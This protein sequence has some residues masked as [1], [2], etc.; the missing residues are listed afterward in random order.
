MTGSRTGVSRPD[1]SKPDSTRAMPGR[2]SPDRSVAEDHDQAPLPASGVA[3]MHGPA[4]P[5]EGT[6]E[7]H[8]DDGAMF[9]R[10]AP[11][12]GEDQGSVSAGA[13]PG[14]PAADGNLQNRG[15]NLLG[16]SADLREQQLQAREDARAEQR[17]LDALQKA[18]VL[19]ND[20]IAGLRGL[21]VGS[22]GGLGSSAVGPAAALKRIDWGSLLERP[23]IDDNPLAQRAM[24]D[25]RRVLDS[26]DSRAMPSVDE[27]CTALLVV[28]SE[29]DRL[30]GAGH[31]SFSV[32]WARRVL[33][34]AAQ[35]A[36]AVAVGLLAAAASAASTGAEVV[37]ALLCAAVGAVVTGL[38]DRA[39]E[40]ARMALR[41][42]APGA[43]LQ[44][45]HNDLA[46][47]AEDLTVFVRRLGETSHGQDRD[48]ALV[49]DTA[50]TA[51]VTAEYAETLAR[52]LDWTST[53]DYVNDLGYLREVLAD[54]AQAAETGVAPGDLAVRLGQAAREL[55]IRTIP[56]DLEPAKITAS[57]PRTARDILME[58][59]RGEA[60]DIEPDSAIHSTETHGRLDAL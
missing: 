24:D 49:R 60:T 37:P 20:T 30:I 29:I 4:G 16:R 26:P 50:V 13:R 14:R 9:D 43:R 42:P 25:L 54:A 57:G 46:Y 8:V 56:G 44:A 31:G 40:A 35:I 52:T 47:M 55:S 15:A 17:V 36:A 45:A 41:P 28:R 18:R 6:V 48:R 51:M 3:G 27:A 33:Q 11:S 7:A 39:V 53:A 32:A 19:V 12:A 23:P 58:T 2:A 1:E 38:C 22:G 21:D 34:I 10:D 59:T 5:I